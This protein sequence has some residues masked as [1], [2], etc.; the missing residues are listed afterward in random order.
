MFDFSRN[1][2][3]LSFEQSLQ[4]LGLEKVDIL[5]FHDVPEEQYQV[6][7]KEGYPAL[8]QLRSQGV[9]KAIGAGM[10]NLELL[11]RFAREGDFDC[12]LLPW[13]YTLVDQAVLSEF[14]PLCVEKGI[15]IIIGAPYD[16]GR[17]LGLTPASPETQERLRRL[18]AVCDRYQVPIRAAALQFVAAHPAVVSVIPGP[19]SVQEI[20]DNISMMQHPIP[21]E[22]WDELRQEQLVPRD[23]PTPQE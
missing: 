13:R 21:L 12:L 4:R 19:R 3:L 2:I 20:K 22:F 9:V 7:I 14:L 17:M 10:G 5:Y 16:G 1:A 11:V 18:N 6:A 23:A 8:A 15:S